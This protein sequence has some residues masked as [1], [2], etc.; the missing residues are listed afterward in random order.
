MK[1]FISYAQNFE[2][3]VLWRAL[4]DIKSGFYVDVGANDP[5]IDSVTLAFYKKGWNG[6]NIE[7]L[8]I[9]HK[10]LLKNRPRDINL[11]CAAGS[12]SGSFKIYDV[13]DVRG[14]ATM[15]A[16]V[17]NEHIKAGHE[18]EEKIVNVEKLNDILYS[19]NPKE[20]H[21]LKIDVEGAE[22]E[23]LNG[24][25]LKKWRPWIILAEVRK[26]NGELPDNSEWENIILVN[27]YKRSY[28]DGINVFYVANE[29]YTRLHQLVSVPPN[30]LDGFIKYSEWQT[31]RYAEKLE[32]LIKDKDEELS[33]IDVNELKARVVELDDV[34]KNIYGSISWK[35]TKPLRFMNWI[36]KKCSNN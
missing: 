21:F 35:I 32:K 31:G 2:D 19:H 16:N 3:V 11:C 25:D 5:V 33:R 30:I 15:D 6:I 12:E 13:K 36:K 22:I 10:E 7:P 18:V 1:Y 34:I 14:W 26:P 27:H 4:K 23:V 17:A 24:L 28:F 8:D 20:I 9:H 29:H